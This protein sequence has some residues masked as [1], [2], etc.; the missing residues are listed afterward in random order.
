[1]ERGLGGEVC[2]RT[3]AYP[4]LTF[5][6]GNRPAGVQESAGNRLAAGVAWDS[7]EQN[8][9]FLKMEFAHAPN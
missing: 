7:I 2:E 4:Y 8:V 3:D 5:T 1:M 6:Y 9:I